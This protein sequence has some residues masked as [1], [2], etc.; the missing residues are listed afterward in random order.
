MGP[1]KIIQRGS[2]IN[3][4]DAYFNS[5]TDKAEMYSRSTVTDKNK[6]ITGD[7]LSIVKKTSWLVDMET[8]S[9]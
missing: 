3:T 9:M 5:K 8:L 6:V 4:T 7:S 2:V 1:S